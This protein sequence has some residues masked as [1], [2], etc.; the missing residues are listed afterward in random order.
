[1]GKV[2]EAAE[3]KAGKG[4]ESAKSEKEEGEPKNKEEEATKNKEE[5]L[6]EKYETGKDLVNG[7]RF[8]EALP[9]FK[10]IE[11]LSPGYRNASDYKK[12][13]EDKVQEAAE[14]ASRK[15]E[16]EQ[17]KKEAEE[18]LKKKEEEAIAAKY[19]TGKDLVNAE[20]FEEALVIFKELEAITPGYRNVTD[21]KTLC[22][23][24]L[25]EAA[26]AKSK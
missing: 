3:K 26:E 17:K 8:E 10:E 25:Q 6:A 5:E 11:A 4:D 2:K 18:T 14:A 22:E 1:M 20:R 19:E 24:K 12:L 16:E 15:V 9:V 13:C 23:Q 7:E 21:Y